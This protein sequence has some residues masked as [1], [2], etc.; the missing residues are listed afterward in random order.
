MLNAVPVAPRNSAACRKCGGVVF[1]VAQDERLIIITC[2]M[3]G[4]ADYAWLA[5]PPD[6]DD[7]LIDHAE[8]R[9]HRLPNGSRAEQAR[10]HPTLKNFSLGYCRNCYFKHHRAKS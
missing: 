2:R 3:C 8:E 7:T 1:T 6:A 9:R 5:R 4:D 10:C